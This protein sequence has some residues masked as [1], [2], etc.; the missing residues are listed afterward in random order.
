[1][2]VVVMGKYHC[3]GDYGSGSYAGSCGSSNERDGVHDMDTKIIVVNEKTIT[4]H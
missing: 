1:M 2:I 4:N 3:C